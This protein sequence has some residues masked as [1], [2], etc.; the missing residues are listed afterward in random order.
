MLATLGLFGWGEMRRKG[1]E[2]QESLSWAG[3]MTMMCIVVGEGEDE[4]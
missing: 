2:G 1:K 4:V 3:W